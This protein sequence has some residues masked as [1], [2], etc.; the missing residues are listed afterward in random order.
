MTSDEL[1]VQIS[2]L[3]VQSLKARA[4]NFEL[5]TWKFELLFITSYSRA[6]ERVSDCV[7]DQLRA[8][9]EVELFHHRVL[10]KRDRARGDV[11]S[12]GDLLHRAPFGE[13][14]EHFFLAQCER[15]RALASFEVLDERP[16]HAL[17][18]ER[19]DVGAAEQQ[20][21]DCLNE[22]AGGGSFDEV[23]RGPEPESLGGEIRVLIHRQV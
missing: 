16:D 4:L 13:E 18:E 11:Q 19:R 15:V 21:S 7:L 2:K 3:Q 17:R 10:V 22:F 9:L 1:K 20:V 23:G 12:E 8:R 5:A 14:L 6:H